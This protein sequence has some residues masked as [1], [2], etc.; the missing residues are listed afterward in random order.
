CIEFLSARTGLPVSAERLLASLTDGQGSF[1]IPGLEAALRRSGLALERIETPLSDLGADCLPALVY[2]PEGEL[3][4]MGVAPRRGRARGI[5]IR[6]FDMPT[7]GGSEVSLGVFALAYPGELYRVAPISKTARI[8]EAADLTE[9]PGRHWFWDAFRAELG[10]Y[11]Y[12]AAAAVLVNVFGLVSSFYTMTVYDRVIPNNALVTL[13][14]LSIGC[15]LVYAFD[16][17]FRMMRGHLIDIASRRL[18]VLVS[19]DLFEQVLSVRLEQKRGGAGT[20]ASMLKDFATVQEFFSSA[21]LIAIVDVPFVFLYLGVMYMLAPPCAIATAAAIP[22]TVMVAMGA[23]AYLR[24]GARSSYKDG[25]EKHGA[26]VETLT[27]LE[28]IRGL[29]AER[30]MRRRWR[31]AVAAHAV[32]G[33]RVRFWQLFAVNGAV[34]VQQISGL[35]VVVVGVLAI[36]QGQMSMGGLIAGV[37]LSSRALAPLSQVAQI[38]SRIFLT[39]ASMRAITRFM[40]A[41]SERP[42]GRRFLDRP[43]ITG[44]IE[45][46]GAAFAYPGPDPVYVLKDLDLVIKP[47]EKVGV[48][49]RIGSGKSTMLKLIMGMYQPIAGKISLDG[50]DIRQLDPAQLRSQVAYVAQTPILFSGS[51]RENLAIARPE[52][53]DAEILRAAEIAGV[54]AFVRGHPQGYDR[55]L[56]ERGEGLSIGQ[57]QAIAIAQALVKDADV[58][59]MDEPTSALDD[60][61][62]TEF[63]A[64]LARAMTDKTLILVTHKL[65]MLELVDRLVVVENGKVVLDGAR[66]AVLRRLQGLDNPEAR[67]A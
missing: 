9:G 20:L 25:V 23:Q 17:A 58:L 47:G 1:D 55:M 21:T 40:E 39:R 50:V 63:R 8:N 2:D 35:A 19:R 54:D 53:T 15:A 52:A 7:E 10:T 14:T 38:L 66:N 26:L 36:Q 12:V 32:S 13:W 59:L 18:D 28:A 4:V 33:A 61:T 44:A 57:R 64:K 45:L 65:S 30:A 42:H 62:E 51:I 11:V 37:M 6:S 56:E 34:S 27:S 22:V 29:G 31:D 67:R 16:M 60:S 48:L 5:E 49:G 41:P 3:R 43:K 24:E 46:R